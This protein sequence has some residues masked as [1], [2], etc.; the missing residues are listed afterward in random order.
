M[1][2]LVKMQRW[3]DLGNSPDLCILMIYECPQGRVNMLFPGGEI[4]RGF[5]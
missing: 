2:I 4:E 3:G 5:L 1:V